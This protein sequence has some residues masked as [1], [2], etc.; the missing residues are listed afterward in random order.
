[1]TSKFRTFAICHCCYKTYSVSQV[2]FQMASSN[3]SLSYRHR[4]EEDKTI[5]HSANIVFLFILQEKLTGLVSRNFIIIRHFRT[6][7]KKLGFHFNSSYGV[8]VCRNGVASTRMLEKISHVC[9]SRPRIISTVKIIQYYK[10]LQSHCHVR[11]A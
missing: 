7:D 3:G 5:Y 9:S 4:H 2:K 8:G 10:G 1:M 6:T 11:Y